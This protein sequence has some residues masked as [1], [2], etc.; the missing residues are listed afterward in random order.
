MSGISE[1]VTK[2]IRMIPSPTV[3]TKIDIARTL[4]RSRLRLRLG[5]N[6]HVRAP[7]INDTKATVIPKPT[8]V[9]SITGGYADLRSGRAVISCHTHESLRPTG[10]LPWPDALDPVGGGAAPHLQRRRARPTTQVG[11]PRPQRAGG[12][13]VDLRRDARRGQ[14]RGLLRR[15]RGCGARGRWARRGARR[16]PRA[17]RRGPARG[18]HGRRDA[19]RRPRRS[20]GRRRTSWRRRTWCGA[21]DPR[22]NRPDR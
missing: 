18:P 7:A 22:A 13:R 20:A 21:N 14:G 9:V 6:S 2:S 15:G 8:E 19:T 3:K 4:E 11:G 5:R 12:G 10:P 17:R 16:R 1:S